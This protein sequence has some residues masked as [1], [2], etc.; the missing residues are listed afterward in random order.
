M[1]YKH[2][3]YSKETPT[4]ITSPTTATAGLQV[5]IGTAPINLAESLESVNKPFLVFSFEE[6]VKALGYSDSW[7]KYNLCEVMDVSFKLYGVSPIVFI[8]VLDPTKHVKVETDKNYQISNKKAVL[9]TEGILLETLEVKLKTSGEVLK[10]N[11]DYISSFDKDGFVSIAVMPDGGINPSETELVVSYSILD[12]TQVTNNDIIGGIDANTGVATGAELINA[13]FPKFGMIPGQILSPGFS[14]NPSVAAVIKAKAEN[15]NTYFKAIAIT[16]IDSEEANTYTKVS[17][18][19][20]QNNYTSTNEIPCWPKVGLDGKIYH[21]STHIAAINA[22][23][24]S[25]NR[26]IPSQSPSNKE[27]KINQVFTENGQEVN[28]GPDQ[29]AYLNGLGI[30]T[31]LNFIG[32]WKSWGNRTGAYPATTDVKDSFIPV[33]RMHTW[34]S[35]SVILS[36]WSRVDSM[37]TKSLANNIVDSLNIWFNGLISNGDLIGGNVEFREEDNPITDLLNGTVR[38]RIRVAEP[39][40]AESIEFMLEFDAT[41]YKNIF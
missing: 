41:Y 36:T 35:N 25:K 3:V 9:D 19:K 13:V 17:E 14:S 34:I 2:G 4:S 33:R 39:T 37:I 20:N 27:L 26:D 28:L 5:V 22:L 11:I 30:M 7:D 1:S 6:A 15:I 40:P 31:A 18:W 21:L 23:T 29:A 32:G 38:F 12:P 8:N 10:N 16:D 24:D